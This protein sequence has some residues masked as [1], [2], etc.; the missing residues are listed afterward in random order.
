MRL[1]LA[2]VTVAVIAAACG[3]STATTSDRASSRPAPH[4]RRRPR[5][6]C[7]PPRRLLRQPHRRRRPPASHRHDGLGRCVRVTDF[8]EPNWF[9]VNDGVMGG[10]SDARG[11]ID[12]SRLEW[13][14]TIVTL[15]GGFRRSA[16]WST[17]RWPARRNSTSNPHRRSGLRTPRRRRRLDPCHALQPDPRRRW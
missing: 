8:D 3:S 16:A 9:I 1:R 4:Q 7:R 11:V 15:G 14:G 17:A 6:P 5:P 10:R 2:I 12:S 13:S